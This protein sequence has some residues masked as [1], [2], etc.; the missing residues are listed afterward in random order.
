[1]DASIARN[2]EVEFL[3]DR[4]YPK[5]GAVRVTGPFT[6]ESLSPH[7]VLPADEED[8]AVV[9]A[10]AAEAGEAPPPRRRLRPKSEADAGTGDDFVTA[11]LDNLAK[12]GVQ[13]TKKNERLTFATIRPW[14]GKGHV[15]A[16][17][18]YE[19]AGQQRRA[20]IVV[21]PEYGT[22]GQELVREAARECRDWADALGD[23][24]NQ[25]NNRQKVSANLLT[26]QHV[27]AVSV[28]GRTLLVIE[29]P[30]GIRRHKPVYINGN[31]MT[32]SY[33]RLNDG[34]RQCDEEIVKRMLAE[35]T[36]E[37]RDNRVLKGFGL[38]DLDWESVRAYRQMMRDRSP[39]HPF[40]DA[41]DEEFLRKIGAVRRD[42]ESGTEGLTVAGLLMF[43]KSE[44]IQD[45]F[46]NYFLDYQERANPKAEQRWVDRVTLDGTW[47]GNLFDFYRRVYRK[48]VA[49]LKV[50][51]ALQNGQRQD[52]TP[53]H[54]AL[55]EALVNTIVH[56]DYTGRAS[57]F[58]V[59]RPDMFGFRNPGLMRVPVAQAIAGGE[60]DGRNRTLQK[61]LLLVGAGERAG[62]GVPKIHKGWAE[63]HWRPPVLYER[64]QPSEQTLLE[65][66]MLDLIPAD[67]LARLRARFGSRF[68][69]LSRDQRLI[70]AAAATEGFVTHARMLSI[71]DMHPT[72]LTRL[73]QGLV[74]EDYLV[75]SGRR[76]AAVYRLPG[77]VLP[78]P[79]TVFG[80]PTEG[81][82]LAGKGSELSTK[83]SELPGQGS[84]LD[85]APTSG[86]LGRQVEGLPYPLIDALEGLDA[87]LRRQ[88]EEISEPVRTSGR[89]APETTRS[90]ITLLCRE[91]YL[92]IRV[93]SALLGRDEDYLRQRVLNPLVHERVLE[94]AFPQSPNDPRQAYTA[95]DVAPPA[96][97]S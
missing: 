55:R 53:V 20:A 30:Q 61:M 90:V 70:L 49:D 74:Q 51:F 36:E 37:S 24:F 64:E 38:E 84:E 54:E 76:R 21:G 71:C 96:S 39:T 57:V 2:A 41:P 23:L 48:L 29:V 52:E 14:P 88:L 16:E 66:R 34:D 27:E 31:P 1:M 83:G 10:L 46:P 28:D 6:V 81:A 58:V 95:A 13:N 72:D 43:G 93:L 8:E 85:S 12:A 42:R 25:L 67:A 35:Q 73:L 78:N 68:D 45:E 77:M 94:R 59:K 75:Q 18:T 69:A 92:T 91:R 33:R 60:S 62:S 40:L 44:S 11:V 3:H 19:E 50:P 17:A 9:E 47:S 80:P 86:S 89:V 97:P 32:G 4:P 63:Q 7:R 26:D 87:G 5:K 22:V 82:E 56:A 15:A 79:D 65:L